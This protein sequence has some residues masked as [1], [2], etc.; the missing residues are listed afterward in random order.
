MSP[1]SAA[2]AALPFLSVAAAG[3]YARYESSLWA[4]PVMD[5]AAYDCLFRKGFVTHVLLEN[6]FYLP[7]DNASEGWGAPAAAQ[8][9]A[10]PLDGRRVAPWSAW[11]AAVKGRVPSLHLGGQVSAALPTPRAP[12]GD[13]AAATR[14]VAAGNRSVAFIVG[15]A[16]AGAL[17]SVDLDVE[18]AGASVPGLLGWVAQLADAL[19][20]RG[21]DLTS[22]VCYGSCG[23]LLDGG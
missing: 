13:V 6:Y 8:R 14:L 18:V 5:L 15:A 12:D 22:A 21:V 1:S 16:V 4:D 20:G 17:D 11:S 9:G 2:G 19:R 23:R 10:A 7:H 3:S